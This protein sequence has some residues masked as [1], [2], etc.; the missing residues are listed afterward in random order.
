M[1]QII[2]SVQ[3]DAAVFVEADNCILTQL[4]ITVDPRVIVKVLKDAGY[5]E[6]DLSSVRVCVPERTPMGT[7][8]N[9][10]KNILQAIKDSDVCQYFS[11]EAV[12]AEKIQ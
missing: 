6:R 2:T 8:Y 1:E 9:S 12:L 11:D 10:Y 7:I 3:C 5:T 4:M